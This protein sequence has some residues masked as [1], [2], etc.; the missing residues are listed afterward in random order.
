MIFCASPD[1]MGRAASYRTVLEE[2]RAGVPDNPRSWPFVIWRHIMRKKSFRE[3]NPN[4]RGGRT[5]TQHGEAA[6]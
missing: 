1:N 3:D 4:W 5:I 2:P 6:L